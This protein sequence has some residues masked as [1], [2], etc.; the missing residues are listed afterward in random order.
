M[1]QLSLF[2]N[3][4]HDKANALLNSLNEG[5]KAKE[6]FM[7]GASVKHKDLIIIQAVNGEKKYYNIL[8]ETGYIPKNFSACWR[9]LKHIIEEL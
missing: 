4:W 8:T 3:F 9:S 6:I 2:E 5:R 1:S 7:A